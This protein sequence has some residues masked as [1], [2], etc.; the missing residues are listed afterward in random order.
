MNEY[1]IFERVAI[2]YLIAFFIATGALFY[3][4][5]F[6]SGVLSAT[7]YL[8]E[9]EPAQTIEP[10]LP[11]NFLTVTPQP[12]EVPTDV[13]NTQHI[14]EILDVDVSM[15]EFHWCIG[16]QTT[17]FMNEDEPRT[18]YQIICTL[19]YDL[20]IDISDIEQYQLIESAFEPDE[21]RVV[22]LLV[23]ADPYVL[24]YHP[25]DLEGGIYYANLIP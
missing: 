17:H 11:T 16:Q 24:W 18:Y 7:P 15:L 8:D 13:Y 12:L 9:K 2:V 22:H 10:L 25:L 1:L 3:A 5:G 4:I 19:A 6:S 23:N 20:D 21:L 14:Q